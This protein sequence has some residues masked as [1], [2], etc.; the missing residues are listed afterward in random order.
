MS[1]Y[2]NN[3]FYNFLIDEKEKLKSKHYYF[4]RT[5]PFI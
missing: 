3:F 5:T 1:R 4:V 2:D